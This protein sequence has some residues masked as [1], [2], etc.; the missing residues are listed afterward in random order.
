[1][2]P[3]GSF[4]RFGPGTRPGRVLVTI[5]V[6]ADTLRRFYDSV[7]VAGRVDEP[8]VVSEERGLSIVVG[9]G[10]RHTLQ[11]VWPTLAGQQ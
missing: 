5:G 9:S 10:A 7:A 3:A 4:W 8:W 1:V 11:E 6:P 2:S